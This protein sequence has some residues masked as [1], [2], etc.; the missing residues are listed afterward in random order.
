MKHTLTSRTRVKDF[1]EPKECQKPK[2]ESPEKRKLIG[3]VGVAPNKMVAKIAIGF[4]T[5]QRDIEIDF[6]SQIW[7]DSFSFTARIL[8]IGL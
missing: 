3:Y 8:M 5:L 6:Q 2:E 4:T 7:T 1:D